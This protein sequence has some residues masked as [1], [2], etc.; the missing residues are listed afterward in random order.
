MA[1]KTTAQLT[2]EAQQIRN[3]TEIGANTAVRIG[4]MLLDI[5]DSKANNGGAIAAPIVTFGTSVNNGSINIQF[6]DTSFLAEAVNPEI[7]LFRWR[8]NR[9]A[10][11]NNKLGDILR[12]TKY[13]RFVHPTDKNAGTR[14]QG[15]RW[16][17]GNQLWSKIGSALGTQV[18]QN[19]QTEWA[20]PPTLA[21]MEKF[22]INFN[23]Y[24]FFQEVDDSDTYL[25]RY[26]VNLF[27]GVDYTLT[28]PR[29]ADNSDLRVSLGGSASKR[30]FTTQKYGKTQKY[31]LAVAVDNPAA[32]KTNGLCPKI[33]SNYSE[34]F[35]TIVADAGND[36]APIGVKM[37]KGESANSLLIRK[38]VVNPNHTNQ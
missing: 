38:N 14:W 6:A 33:F 25:A 24:M 30:Q 36:N 22:S 26:D 16:F 35:Y 10:K 28:N 12:R 29:S 9:K 21:P 34:I 1:Q 2:L 27:N 13:A 7:F 5:V 19:R 37:V 23:I 17:N 4:D 15:W 32:T 8:K 11:Y 31:C 18:L 3:E 20:I